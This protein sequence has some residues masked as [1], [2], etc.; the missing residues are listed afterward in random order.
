MKDYYVLVEKPLDFDGC[1]SCQGVTVLMWCPCCRE[2][3]CG[4]CLAEHAARRPGP[5]RP[6]T[7]T[8][9]G[10]S[11]RRAMKGGPV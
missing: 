5:A 6:A 8:T 7:S 4:R 3:V 9:S 2:W 10:R 11:R 1:A